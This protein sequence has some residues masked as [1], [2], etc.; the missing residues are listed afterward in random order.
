MEAGYNRELLLEIAHKIKN[1]KQT[2]AEQAYYDLWYESYEDSLLELPKGY[3]ANPIAIR[4]RM[5]EN[6]KSKISQ[7]TI[8]RRFPVW[9]KITSAAA[10]L[11]LLIGLLL[12]I[13]L[14]STPAT[15]TPT[16]T[17]SSILP[18]SN[19]A[20]LTLADGRVISL[21]QLAPGLIATENGLQ[22]TK[23]KEGRIA[24]D[25]ATTSKPAVLSYNSIAVPQG[26]T[27]QVSLQDGS[28]V[29]LNAGSSLK[30]PATFAGLTERKVDLSGEGYF[31]VAK[32]KAH[33]FIVK[34]RQ[35]EV[36]VLGTHFNINAYPDELRVVTT[37]EEGRVKVSSGG[38]Y[39]TINPGERTVLA[40]EGNMEVQQADLES[41][42]AWKNGKIYFKDADIRSIL[43]QVARWYDIDVAY[44]GK[45]PTKL[46]TGGVYRNSNLSTILEILQENNIHFAISEPIKGKKLLTVRF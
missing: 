21:D 33:P 10:A 22:I 40:S 34:T 43:R 44:E 27:Y 41:A 46:Y 39:L 23:D 45:I 4:D 13:N 31:E 32:D 2:I 24:Y 30:Y 35:Q 26:G 11:I 5:H 20:T 38:S 17:A 42:L 8:V 28:R 18:G 15:S 19:K 1:G 7:K 3:A 25:I 9:I 37:L 12:Y 36:T 6:I 29:W 14:K 16:I